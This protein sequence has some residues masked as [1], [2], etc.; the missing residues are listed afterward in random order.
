MEDVIAWA[1]ELGL[2]MIPPERDD[3]IHLADTY[4]GF[5]IAERQELFAVEVST[6]E[7]DRELLGAFDDVEDAR[8]FL[9]M[10]FG[11]MHRGRSA[12]P[13]LRAE[14]PQP[15]YVLEETPTSL[16][17]SWMT[18]SAEFP[19]DYFSRRRAVTF[20]RVE[21]ADVE[22]IYESYREPGG[23]PLFDEAA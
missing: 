3:L 4:V 12:L 15:G 17:L 5:S 2:V 14:E 23:R 10:E 13:P 7:H 21:R 22:E 16:W 1:R 8:R 20:S 19:A 9:V 18:G 11:V 6:R